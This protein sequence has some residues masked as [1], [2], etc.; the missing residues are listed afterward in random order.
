MKLNKTNLFVVLWLMHLFV[1]YS[2]YTLFLKVYLNDYEDFYVIFTGFI[3]GLMGLFEK[4]PFFVFI[5]FISM[6]LL[7]KTKF[8]NHWFSAF[9]ISIVSSYLL[10]YIWMLSR[11]THRLLLYSPEKH[12]LIYFI[13]PSLLFS[14]LANWLIFRKNYRYHSV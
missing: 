1:Y 3:V 4:V 14:I 8:K 6:L 7:I 5:P 2:I 12:N 13:I 11:N 9:S 10:N